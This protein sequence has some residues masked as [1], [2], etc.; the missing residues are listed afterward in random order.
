M[1][2]NEIHPDGIDLGHGDDTRPFTATAAARGRQFQPAEDTG[3]GKYITPTSVPYKKDAAP[4][5]KDGAPQQ[6]DE[7]KSRLDQ[8][9]DPDNENGIYSKDPDKQKAAMVELRKLLAA[10][11]EEQRILGEATLED[12]RSFYGLDA[13][14]EHVLPKVYAEEYEREF[15]GHEEDYLAAARQHGLDTTLVRELR[16]EG[17]RMAIHAQGAPV[18]EEQWQAFDARFGERLTKTQITALKNWWRTSVERGG[19]AA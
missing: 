14:G 5:Q 7:Q 16:D 18:S 13:P 9:N 4:Q 6:K 19:D 17:I 3:L 8:L 10:D 12:N 11:P 1:V 2:P 15:S